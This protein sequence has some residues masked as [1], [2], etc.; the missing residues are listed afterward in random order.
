MAPANERPGGD[1]E[2]EPEP[3]EGPFTPEPSAEADWFSSADGEV[4]WPAFASPRRSKDRERERAEQREGASDRVR[5]LF[6]VPDQ[7]D[8]DVGEL[9]YEKKRRSST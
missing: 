1:E 4:E 8:W 5:Y 7:T 2:R 3:R 6:P 9:R